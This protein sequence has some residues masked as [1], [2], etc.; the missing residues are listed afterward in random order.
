MKA[1][2]STKQLNIVEA[3]KEKKYEGERFSQAVS[4]PRGD[5]VTV[6]EKKAPSSR[7]CK[8][9]KMDSMSTLAG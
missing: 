1:F 3:L 4:E 8:I 9:R 7:I 5:V 6:S 2:L